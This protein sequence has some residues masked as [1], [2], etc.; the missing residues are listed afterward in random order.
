[1][2]IV[3]IEREKLQVIGM[4]ITTN[5]EEMMI[6]KF[7]DIFIK[8]MPEIELFTIPNCSLGI[9]LGGTTKE[10]E[11]STRFDYLACKILTKKPD[12]IPENM[13]VHEV[14]A[15]L[16]AVFTH[17]GNI[18]S[19]SETYQYIYDQWLE[20]SVYEQED[21]DQ[22]EWYDARFQYDSD[23][24]EIDIHIPIKRGYSKQDAQKE[25]TF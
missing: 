13:I 23:Q 7:W 19:L 14:P 15:G 3:V 10:D 18:D 24:S 4:K 16:F 11:N 22:I 8:R 20:E 6:P 17:R 21:R 9:C 12:V 2:K 1:M 5:T 25:E